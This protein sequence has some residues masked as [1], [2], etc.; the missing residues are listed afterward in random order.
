MRV[1]IIAE[2]PLAPVPGGT[3]R[4]TV[5]L[6]A[7]LARTAGPG[8]RITGWTAWH[9][10]LGAARIPGVAGPRRLALPRRPLVAAWERG[11]GPVPRGTDLVHAPTPLFPPTRTPL[12]VTVHDAV[13]WTH[14]ETLTP[15]GVA[16]HRT[17]AQR[18][19]RS[20]AAIAVPTHAVAEQLAERL[21][22]SAEQLHVLGGGVAPALLAEPEPAQA[23]VIARRLALPERYL[24]TVATLEP[25]KG[26]DVLLAALAS[27]GPGAPPLLVVGQ[28]GWGDVDLASAARSAGLADG[29]VRALGRISDAELAVVL[30]SA[31][32]LVAPSRAEGFGLPVAEAMAVGTPVICADDP[33]LVEVSGG[34]AMIVA[35]G[36]APQLAQVIEDVL[37]NDGLRSRLAAEGRGRASAYTWDAVAQ[38]TWALYRN[39]AVTTAG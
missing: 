33:A 3:G 1:A 37:D 21:G 8:E 2:Q 18:A 24:L 20:G 38:R 23:T 34:A 14:P 29:V 7:A 16:W 31:T 32:V 17:M 36:D 12:V 10:D 22:M 39:L 26:L 28:A 19:A 6:A 4:Y 27:L 13:P 25:R 35:R 15:R 9:R 11:V 30:R 5:E